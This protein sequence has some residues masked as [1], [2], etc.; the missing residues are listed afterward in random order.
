MAGRKRGGKKP[1]K[2]SEPKVAM[3]YRLSPAKIAR[4]RK[5]LGT[6]TATSTI[7]EALDLVIFRDELT[8][9]LDAAFG[10]AIGERFPDG[11]TRS[12]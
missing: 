4:A 2:V 6:E 8:S 3:S 10:L 12:R 9:G 11:S 5:I 1:G 7:E